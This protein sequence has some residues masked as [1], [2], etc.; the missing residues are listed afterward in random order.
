LTAFLLVSD[1]SFDRLSR[2]LLFWLANKFFG[3]VLLQQLLD[4]FADLGQF[5]I[6]RWKFVGLAVQVF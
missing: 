5:Q 1:G 4:V 3:F 2:L 6:V